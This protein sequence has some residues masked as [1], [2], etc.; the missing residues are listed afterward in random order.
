MALGLELEAAAPMVR[1]HFSQSGQSFQYAGI[2]ARAWR[3]GGWRG[4]L[5]APVFWLCRRFHLF[6]ADE[7]S[8]VPFELDHVMRK[9]ADGATEMF[10]SRTLHFPHGS[11]RFEGVLGFDSALC[12]PIEWLGRG[13]WLEAE[14]H[15]RIVHR[16]VCT[17]TGR[18]WL[19]IGRLRLR[20]P[21]LLAGQASL[22]E[23]QQNDGTLGT[24]CA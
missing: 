21:R 17:V 22:R 19:R 18:Q 13:R 2:M 11:R 12:L 9:A 20:V 16:D 24:R 4:V 3:C 23:W 6:L 15:C 5:A 7:G 8:D 1:E 14:L 10:W